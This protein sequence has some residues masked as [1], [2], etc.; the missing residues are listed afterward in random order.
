MNA[1]ALDALA[2]RLRA[3]P[4]MAAKADIGL[5]ATRL[6]LTRSAIPVG[7]DCAAIPDG[8]GHI[9]FAAEGFI[10]EFVSSDPWF[11]G[12]CGVMVNLSDIAAMGGRPVAVVD[13]VWAEGEDG[14]RAILDG[15]RAA[16]RAYGVPIV[17]GHTNLRTRQQQLA[18][19]VLGRA[20]ARLLTSFDAEPGDM[21]IMIVDRRGAYR[22]PFDNF[23]AAL[24]APAERLRADLAL[25]PA[26][27]EKS[28]A[29][30]AKDISQPAFRA[31]RRCSPKARACRSRS[32]STPSSRR[33]GWS[34]SAGSGPFRAS[35][36][37]C[38]SP[39]GTSTRSLQSFARATC[40]LPRSAP[41]SRARRS[42]CSLKA[43]APSCGTSAPSN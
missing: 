6:G 5:V 32:I 4:A 27:A 18:V 40:M 31:R 26:L 38:P 28:L 1:A 3:N 34:S 22:E 33:L 39:R 35:A 36:F 15:L 43:E 30:A 20:G 24:E 14:A 11:A 9:L 23:Q 8:D 21:L 19:A 12:W 10:N 2:E 16:A 25:L 41:S 29:R 13:V 37:F 17:G 7:D 42:R